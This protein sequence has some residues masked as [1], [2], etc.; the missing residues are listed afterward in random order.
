MRARGIERI[1]QRGRQYL[2]LAIGDGVDLDGGEIRVEPALAA[3]GIKRM[4]PASREQ[5]RHAEQRPA[6]TPPH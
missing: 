3:G 6:L 1:A 2:P 4:K 5:Q